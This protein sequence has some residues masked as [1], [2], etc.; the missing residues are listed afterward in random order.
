MEFAGS[1][2]V[3]AVLEF[4]RCS[5]YA[6]S[7]GR[8]FLSHVHPVTGRIHADFQQ[9]GAPTGRIQARTPPVMGIPKAFEFRDSIRPRPG[10][11][12][13]VADCGQM[14]LRILA[15]LSGDRALRDAFNTGADLHRG[16]AARMYGVEEH[17]VTPAQRA[18]AKA[19]NFGMSYG[20]GPGGLATRLKV[21]VR[22]AEA[23][24]AQYFRAVPGVDRYLAEVGR[25]AA[26][27]GW[28][29]VP[30]SGRLI[31][32]SDG[33]PSRAERGHLERQGKNAPMQATN[34][35]VLKRALALLDATIAEHGARLVNCVHDEVVVEGPAASVDAIKQTVER[36]IITAAREFVRSVPVVVDLSAGDSW[37]RPGAERVFA[38]P[39]YDRGR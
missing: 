12:F 31:T 17:D 10:E 1:P 39:R 25:H 19:I 33:T 15:E 29:R 27:E 30:G 18:S 16:M 2:I 37:A 34:A 4:K 14:E 32:Y 3:D 5:G 23:M 36:G 7:Y 28:V 24:I 22:A 20:M 35:D 8:N 38:G 6:A 21:D 9:I 13:V 26:R 11:M